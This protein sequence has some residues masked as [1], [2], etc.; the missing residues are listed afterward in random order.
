MPNA[1]RG[2]LLAEGVRHYEEARGAPLDEPAAEAAARAAGGD[3]EE[4]IIVRA[5][6]LTIAAPLLAA[7]ARLRETTVIATAI[8]AII[9]ASAGAAS[10]RVVL[11]SHGDGPVNVFWAI[12]SLLGL[13]TLTL[14]IWLAL[15]VFGPGGAA[16]SILGRGVAAMGGWLSR[17][18]G[19]GHVEL[20]AVRAASSVHAEGK[21][22]CWSLSAM[23]HT[24]WIAFLTGCILSA[25][26]MLGTRQYDFAWETTILSEPAYITATRTLA[27]PLDALGFAVPDAEQV[28]ASRWRA[29]GK[30]FGESRIAWG[31]LLIGCLL[32]YGLAPRSVALLVSLIALS[33]ARRRF[34]LDLTHA[35]FARLSR[36]LM[37]IAR[38]TGVRDS[39]DA[40]RRDIQDDK[41]IAP[42]VLPIA[43]QGPAGILGFEIEPPS[44]GWPPDLRGLR[45]QDFGFIDD[46]QDRQRVIADLSEASGLRALVVVCSLAATPDRGTGVVLDALRRS[47]PC[48][49]VVVLSDGQRV[50]ERMPRVEVEQRIADWQALAMLAGVAAAYIVACDLPHLT[51]ASRD[52]LA[53]LL[54]GGTGDA[55][56]PDAHAGA[57]RLARAFALIVS[58][59]RTW[60]AAPGV[61]EQAALHRAIADVYAS[62][63]EPRW[64]TILRARA[65]GA[66][67]R[68]DDLKSG[69]RRMVALLPARLRADPRWLAA[70]AA[71]GALG[72]IAA[73]GLIA[74]AA[75]AALPAW[76]GLGAGAAALLGPSLATSH[77]DS[78]SPADLSQAVRAA[79]LFALL[80]EL[81]G[82]DEA[83]IGRSLD[84]IVG[85]DVPPPIADADTARSWLDT[86]AQ[87]FERIRGEEEP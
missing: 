55:T 22:A 45:W 71:A 47:S 43:G 18:F 17:R 73:A 80:L 24:L 28:A 83:A 49:L 70:G 31:G 3:L 46:R 57:E 1:A 16:A 63:G 39:D 34:R 6:H 40:M 60:T 79:A 84:G 82:R 81:Q 26:I 75:I 13:H 44:S 21:S 41:T 37:P 67:P 36:R 52:R 15:I 4:R 7:F 32:L 51:D 68:L 10:V 30:A 62:S 86:L 66:A 48:P 9:A 61:H 85:D 14:L 2:R 33:C 19:H 78:D 56:A 64:Q 29:E 38:P 8:A 42:D 77:N 69:A 53:R 72:C 87:R 5:R 58:R 11:G 23:A 74:P 76:A 12:A 20:A 35:G 50:R 27:T 25:L 54:A 59:A 65:A